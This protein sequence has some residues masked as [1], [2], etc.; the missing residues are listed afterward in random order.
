MLGKL[1]FDK[2]NG[3]LLTKSLDAAMVRSRAISN[4]VANINTPGYK[5][6]EVSFEKQLA[7][8][9]DSKILRGSRTNSRHLPLGKLAIDEVQPQSFTP[10]DPTLASG[11][12]NVDID[13]EMAKLAENQILFNFSVK[14]LQGVYTKLNAAIQGRA[15][16][17]Q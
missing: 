8:A 7:E 10:V 16:P 4:N 11:V 5:R 3:P 15:L 1:L 9:L 2:T 6:V 17:L 13:M 14:R 12:N